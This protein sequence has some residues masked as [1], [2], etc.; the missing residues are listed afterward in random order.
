MPSLP[1]VAII[2]ITS[3]QKNAKAHTDMT[4]SSYHSASLYDHQWQPPTPSATI[5]TPN[6]GNTEIPYLPPSPQTSH[7][8][9]QQQPVQRK[10]I[11]KMHTMTIVTPPMMQST[12]VPQTIRHSIARSPSAISLSARKRSVS[13]S[14]SHGHISHGDH[15]IIPIK[16]I[17]KSPTSTADHESNHHHLAL[18]S[19]LNHSDAVSGHLERSMRLGHNS[20]TSWSPCFVVV[21][22]GSLHIFDCDASFSSMP[23][24]DMKPVSSLSLNST[25]RLTIE[26]CQ[27]T[28]PSLNCDGKTNHHDGGQPSSVV[29]IVS[30]FTT[31]DPWI[32]RVSSASN[33]QSSPSSNVTPQDWIKAF[34]KQQHHYG[35]Q[36]MTSNTIKKAYPEVFRPHIKTAFEHTHADS[37]YRKHSRSSSG[38]SL[39]SAATITSDGSSSDGV[40]TPL[41]PSI[42]LYQ[43]DSQTGVP[44]I[45]RSLSSNHL[46]SHLN[47]PPTCPLPPTPSQQA[48]QLSSYEF[49]PS[50]NLNHYNRSR[51]FSDSKS[52]NMVTTNTTTQIQIPTFN[53]AHNPSSSFAYPLTPTSPSNTSNVSPTNNN[54]NNN[55][56]MVLSPTRPSLDSLSSHSHSEYLRF[57]RDFSSPSKRSIDVTPSS[58]HQDQEQLLSPTSHTNTQNNDTPNEL[59]R[60]NSFKKKGVNDFFGGLMKRKSFVQQGAHGGATRGQNSTANT[61]TS[62]D[63]VSGPGVFWEFK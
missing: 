38:V 60:R 62:E 58:D 1:L 18:N 23:L 21:V 40:S 22:R 30:S 63:A 24:P 5:N 9:Q 11:T 35:L 15:S 19:L 57:S 31:S 3:A 54:N 36:V 48:Q 13:M 42:I 4:E 49:P 55:N 32:L 14:A 25:S 26:L 29:F 8:I 37:V 50:L 33:S 53:V 59:T 16:S 46:K 2:T 34:Q 61:N 41:S 56:N 6:Y 47:N 20:Q 27:S 43:A 45:Q 44:L 10:S 28:S 39:A 12:P 52:F 51:T 17:D 7:I